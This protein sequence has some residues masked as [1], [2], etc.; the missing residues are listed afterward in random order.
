MPTEINLILLAVIVCFIVDI[1]GIISSIKYSIWKKLF[2]KKGS[3]ENIKLKPFDCSLCSTWWTTIIYIICTNNFTL[4]YVLECAML[5][6][7]SK[8]ITG[9]LMLITDALTALENKISNKLF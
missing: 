6:M 9:F 1:S 2:K 8:N 4:I 3:P 5:A 7:L